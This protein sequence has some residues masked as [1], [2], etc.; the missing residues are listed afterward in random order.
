M[1][2]ATVVITGL[3]AALFMSTAAMKLAGVT[4]S[5]A[6]RDHLGVAAPTWRLIGVLELAGASGALL[7]LA[8]PQ[9]GIAACA[10]LVLTS[11]GAI[12]THLRAGDPPSAAAPALLAL[13]LAI[14]ALALQAATA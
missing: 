3:L 4:Q 11:L 6:I 8:V 13:A 5:L 10:G 2:T 9:L 7:G 14:A 12:S 1:E